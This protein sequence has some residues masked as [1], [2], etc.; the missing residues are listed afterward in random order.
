[1]TFSKVV[2]FFSIF[3]FSL[4]TVFGTSVY[5]EGGAFEV[6]VDT[7]N[8][9]VFSN[10]IESHFF[11][12][13]KNNLQVSQKIE[14]VVGPKSGWDILL[15]D[16]KIELDSKEEFTFEMDLSSN[17]A[18]DYTPNVVSP[19]LIKISQNNEAYSGFFEFPVKVL[20]VDEVSLTYSVNIKPTKDNLKFFTKIQQTAVSPVNAL[21]FTVNSEAVTKDTNVEISVS[22][23]DYE[24]ELIEDVFTTDVSYKIYQLD[25]PSTIIPEAYDVKVT[26]RVL[27]EGGESAQEWY[28][29]SNIVVAPYRNIDVV[30]SRG[31]GIFR[32]RV[33]LIITNLGNENDLFTDELS[34]GFFRSL[35]FGTDAESYIDS[36]NGIAFQ[37]PL[38]K[39]ESKTLT[40][41][42]NYL[43]LVIVILIIVIL[44]F[45]VYVRKNSNPLVVKNQLF[46][47]ERVKH[48]G[49]KG[50]KVRIGFENIKEHELDKLKVIFRMPGYLQVKDDSFSL[51]EP[52]HV[53]KGDSQYKLV[54]DFKRFEKGD[55]RLLGFNL[56]NQKGILGDIRLPDLELEV[57]LNG[58]TRKYY[59]SFPIIKG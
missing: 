48:E 38:E 44:A 15:S 55:T 56:V 22:L 40:Y 7:L 2:G 24:F 25:V 50:F 23:G 53:L 13:V 27:S 21:K 47:V 52:K 39:G 18:F 1:M 8:S 59:Q 54:W 30:E 26:T 17:S 19:N 28:S 4:F 3:I 5:N 6:T 58:K 20:G 14:F 43:A 11:I 37:V 32:D 33:E 42:F 9:E 46:E 49:V 16:R 34:F 57:K 29:N 51:T 35:L 45:Y 10:Q 41:S 31:K 12:T 36:E